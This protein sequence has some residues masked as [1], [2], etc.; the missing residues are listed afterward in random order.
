MEIRLAIEKKCLSKF[1]RLLHFNNVL[2]DRKLVEITWKLQLD[3][4]P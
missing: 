2:R 3:S 4:L 1:F